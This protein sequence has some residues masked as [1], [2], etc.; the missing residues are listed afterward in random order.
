MSRTTYTMDREKPL[1]VSDGVEAAGT[2]ATDAKPLVAQWNRVTKV[3][4]GSGVLLPPAR[5]GADILIVRADRG[6]Y[7]NKLRIYP[8]PG[9]GIGQGNGV[10]IMASTFNG[11]AV[12]IACLSDGIWDGIA[13]LDASG[14][15]WHTVEGI[16]GKAALAAAAVTLNVPLLPPA[17]A[18]RASL[19]VK[20]ARITILH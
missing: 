9:D 4:A 10:L 12:R 20:D 15:D 2:T 1:R 5:V 11:N 19:S 18:G 8:A 6:T 14:L 7:G 16:G 17:L 13:A 3:T